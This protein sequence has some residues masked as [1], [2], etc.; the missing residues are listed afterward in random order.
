MYKNK[1]INYLLLSKL[2]LLLAKHITIESITNHYKNSL[3]KK[4][5]II[6]KCCSID[7]GGAAL[8]P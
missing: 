1:P 2:L 5:L 6:K 4:K 8:N 3:P 7:I